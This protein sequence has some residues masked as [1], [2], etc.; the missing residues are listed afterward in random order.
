MVYAT[1]YNVT[2]LKRLEAEKPEFFQEYGMSKEALAVHLTNNMCLPFSK[3]KSYMFR[4]T[5]AKIKEK[6]YLDDQI[7]RLSN[8]GD[9]FHP[10][11]WTH[12]ID[13]LECLLAFFI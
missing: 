5:T 11:L 6:S 10:Y 2:V 3:L 9:K 8:G 1:S 13:A 7:R 12:Q 4:D